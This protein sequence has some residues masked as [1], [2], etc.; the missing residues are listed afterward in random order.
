MS[1]FF[2][3][4]FH[5]HLPDY[6]AD[7]QYAEI[8]DAL[9]LCGTQIEAALGA[10]FLEKV[11]DLEYRRYCVEALAAFR[12]GFRL[13]VSLFKSPAPPAPPAPAGKSRRSCSACP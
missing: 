3:E 12:H 8:N 6:E 9:S 4:Y 11:T 2:T 5:E 10:E 13:A 1:D 7:P